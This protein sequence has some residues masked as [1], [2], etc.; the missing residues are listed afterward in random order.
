MARILTR[1]QVYAALECQS[2]VIIDGVA[3][4]I[5]RRC[6]IDVLLSRLLY[7][8]DV[9]LFRLGSYYWTYVERKPPL[10]IDCLGRY[11]VHYRQCRGSIVEF[12]SKNVTTRKKANVKVV[13]VGQGRDSTS[14]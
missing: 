9:I 11:V 8:L 13:A 2:K 7:T 4:I 12:H 6:D 3:L 10:S 1:R 5:A 14:C